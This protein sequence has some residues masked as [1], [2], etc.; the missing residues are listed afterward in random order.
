MPETETDMSVSL[1]AGA[2]VS[3]STDLNTFYSALFNGKLLK[4]ET[5]EKMIDIKDKYGY[6]IIK[7]PFEDKLVYGHSGGIDGF[8]SIAY[9]LPKEKVAYSF[10]LN[11]LYMNSAELVKGPLKI[12]FGEEYE[13]PVF[14]KEYDPA[15][16]DLKSYQG[17]YS[18]PM[19]P[20]KLKVFVQDEVL[21]AQGTNQPS[22]MLD[23]VEKHEFKYDQAK[24]KIEFKPSENKLMLS[25][26]GG[27]FELTNE[28][29]EVKA[30]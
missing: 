4:A 12:Y 30:E 17:T 22:F 1:G 16:S 8:A 21:M 13:L 3:T 23:P 15:L 14:K 20:I 9:Y 2:I 10:I 25:Q 6:G 18:T 5:F 19:L 27:I 26:G 24:L 11:G 7:I 28:K 29:E